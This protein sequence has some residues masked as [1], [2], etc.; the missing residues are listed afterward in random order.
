MRRMNK[1]FMNRNGRIIKVTN[2]QAEN[3]S[4][5]ANIAIYALVNLWMCAFC[6]YMYKCG[7]QD[8]IT[9]NNDK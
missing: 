8:P 9:D 2:G 6:M 7:Q 4:L 3:I 1:Y 5:K